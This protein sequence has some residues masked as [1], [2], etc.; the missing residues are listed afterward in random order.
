MVCILKDSNLIPGR[1]T[2]EEPKINSLAN[3]FY[4]YLYLILPL[5][6][7]YRVI[8]GIVQGHVKY[9]IKVHLHVVLVAHS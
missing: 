9:S 4:L 3:A 7:G 2:R 5:L 1:N 8:E 6:L